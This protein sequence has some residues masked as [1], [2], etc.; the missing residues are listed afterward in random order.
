MPGLVPGMTV[1]FYAAAAIFQFNVMPSLSP[2]N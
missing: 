1:F 2:E